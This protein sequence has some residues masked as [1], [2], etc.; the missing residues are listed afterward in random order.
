M[1]FRFVVFKRS[2]VPGGWKKVFECL[3]DRDAYHW[4]WKETNDNN[5]KL[6]KFYTPNGVVLQGVK[7]GYEPP[8]P[9]VKYSEH[10]TEGYKI[11]RMMV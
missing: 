4:V 3:T 2:T 11:L 7:D 1:K 6:V 9:G 5:F 8:I 10:T